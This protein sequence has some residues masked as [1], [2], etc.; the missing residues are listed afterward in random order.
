MRARLQSVPTRRS[1][2]IIAGV[3]AACLLAG[4]GSA[5]SARADTGTTVTVMTRNLYFGADLAPVLASTTT[6]GFF[7]AVRGAY[8]QGETLAEG[9]VAAPP[10]AGAY[11]EA[12]A[13]DGAT[14]TIGVVRR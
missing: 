14:V 12:F 7:D 8:L 4:A 13:L 10:P 3:A 2:R 9:L 5:S 11:T 6:Q 1:R